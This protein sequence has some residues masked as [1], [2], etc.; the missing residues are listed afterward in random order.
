MN[1]GNA[2]RSRISRYHPAA[3]FRLGDLPE[4]VGLNDASNQ[5]RKLTP[6]ISKAK[7]RP[8]GAKMK[9]GKRSLTLSDPEPQRQETSPR[10]LLPSR[11]CSSEARAVVGKKQS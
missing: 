2:A 5:A 7:M 10:I 8:C 3:I 9:C 11:A 4:A 1:A 6:E